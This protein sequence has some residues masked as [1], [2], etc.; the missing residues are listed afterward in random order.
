MAVIVINIKEER[1]DSK[2]EAPSDVLES[3]LT[4]FKSLD[5]DT[6]DPEYVR[7]LLRRLPAVALEIRQS[8]Y[9]PDWEFGKPC[10]VCRNVTLSAMTVSEDIY[11]SSDGEFEYVK[12]GD[13]NGP[14]L[15]VVC[16]ECRTHLSHV[17]YQN[18]TS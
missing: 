5:S 11:N 16:P 10:P 13:A 17:P 3:L 9:E 8:T 2:D 6:V 14:V 4:P 7:K 15:S 12:K 1:I 18:L